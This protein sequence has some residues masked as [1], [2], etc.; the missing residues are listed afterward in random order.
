MTTKYLIPVNQINVL[1]QIH[2]LAIEVVGCFA[3]VD[4]VAAVDKENSDGVILGDRSPEDL[5]PVLKIELTELPP[6]LSK[7]PL[8]SNSTAGDGGIPC[9]LDAFVFRSSNSAPAIP[10]IRYADCGYSA[11]ISPSSGIIIVNWGNKLLI[12]SM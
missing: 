6:N 2:R 3:A 11:Y 1:V 4:T 7:G 12:E 10:P 9:G 8:H 5:E